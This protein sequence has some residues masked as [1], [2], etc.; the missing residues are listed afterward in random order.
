MALI[1]QEVSADEW[2]DIPG[3]VL[4]TYRLWRPTPLIRALDLERPRHPGPHLLQVRGGSPAGSHKPNTAV[5]QAFYNK[6]EGIT[7]SAPR[8]APASGERPGLR[9]CPL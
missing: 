6:A 7:G 3:P 8:P 9:L 2:V 4:D 5:P 1:G